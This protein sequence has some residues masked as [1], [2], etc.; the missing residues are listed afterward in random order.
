MAW[1]YAEKGRKIGPLGKDELSQLLH[2]GKINSRTLLWQEGM[3]SWQELRNI[4]ALESIAA[5]IPP[6]IPRVTSPQLFELTPAGRWRRWLARIFDVW[7]EILLVTAIA[8]YVLGR[9]FTG[10]ASWISEPGMNQLFT[11]ACLPLALLLDAVIYKL[12]GNTPGKALLGLRVT[13]V[14][15]SRLSFLQYITRNCSVWAM[16][17]AFGIPLLNLVTMGNQSSL[18]SRG[19]RAS[20]DEASGD[21]VMGPPLR[22]MPSIVFGVCF[23]ALLGVMGWLQTAAEQT[24]P[25]SPTT[26]ST[27]PVVSNIA[28][29]YQWENPITHRTATLD[30][31]WTYS[32]K[33]NPAGGQVFVF[34]EKTGR[35]A[36]VFASE[37]A[38]GYGMGDYSPAYR[39]N[40]EAT[41][42]FSDSGR[43]F[44]SEGHEMWE[45]S[46]FFGD[47]TTD[48]LHVQLVHDGDQFWR[49]VTVQ[50]PPYE[51]S[52]QTA[53][54]LKASLLSTVL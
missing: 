23:T 37:S 46:G 34:A 18:I 50:N 32:V 10:F 33:P 45:G 31:R 15:G 36:V 7:W 54:A 2:A 28:Q 6:E 11:I 5:S 38:P 17:L 3:E 39:K 25:Q 9:Y 35:A 48:Q 26:N 21:Q 49:V 44:A 19:K 1:W 22:W 51:Y 29:T 42:H 52:D 30:S 13:H 20:Y 14:D 53:T 8:G 24:R 4:P 43:F 12:T 27:S 16:G 40:N 47:K 41:L